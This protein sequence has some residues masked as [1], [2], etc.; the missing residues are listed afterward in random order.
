MIP[1][2]WRFSTVSSFGA[3]PTRQGQGIVSPLHLKVIYGQAREFYES[4]QK[5]GLATRNWTTWKWRRW[6]ALWAVTRPRS[7]RP[8]RARS[9]AMSKSLCRTN[10]SGKRSGG[11][12]TFS[13]SRTTEFSN[14][15]PSANPWLWSI[16]TSRIKPKVR[17]GAI[18]RAK[19]SW[20]N[21]R[22]R[23]CLPMDG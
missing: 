20:R 14:D 19:V 4:V 10:S 18:S 17:A 11:F 12:I 2:P 15:A 3:L 1:C 8:R 22:L 21:V 16:S 23:L 13:S 5:S 6:P 7:G 9:P